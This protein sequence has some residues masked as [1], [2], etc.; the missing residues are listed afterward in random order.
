[1]VYP[2]NSSDSRSW[3]SRGQSALWSTRCLVM[4][5]RNR[6]Q[7]VTLHPEAMTVA[8]YGNPN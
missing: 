4:A 3:Q 2:A 1:M 6:H 5:T 8:L 7:L